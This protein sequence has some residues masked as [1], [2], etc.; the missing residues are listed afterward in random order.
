[1]FKKIVSGALVIL[2]VCVVSGIPQVLFAASL[3]ALSDTMSDQNA[4]AASSHTIR[5]TTPTGASDNTDTI[6]ITFPSD[7]NFTSKTIGSVSFTHGSTT[8]AETTETLASSATGSA[9]G[10]AFSGTQNRV[11]TLTAPTDGVGAASLAASDKVIITYDSTNSLNPSST[12]S[13]TIAITGS[14]GD[15]GNIAIPIVAG[16]AGDDSVAITANV[17]PSITFTNDDAAI[18]FGTLSASAATYANAGATG[19]SSDTTAHTMTVGTNAAG[20]YTI[21]YSGATLTSGG[22]TI[23]AINAGITDDANGTPGSEQFAISGA[24][25][26]TGSMA[27]GYDNSGTADWRFVPSTTTTLASHTGVVSSDSIAMHYLANIAANTEA[28]SYSNTIT[29]IATGNF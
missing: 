26:G 5:F 14:F 10:A 11:L 27:S 28:G 13:F 25:T 7:F 19:S 16:G 6:I 12:G 15:T 2:F 21:T 8:G 29:Y 17:D 3:T 9:W 1:M 4:S 18:G 22:N 24:L 23:T 20:G